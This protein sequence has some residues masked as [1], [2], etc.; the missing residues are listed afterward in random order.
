MEAER[1]TGVRDR[2]IT[3]A[4]S[5]RQV[6]SDRYT[7]SRLADITKMSL[8]QLSSDIP[9]AGTKALLIELAEMRTGLESTHVGNVCKIKTHEL[10]IAYP[11]MSLQQPTLP[12][13]FRKCRVH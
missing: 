7:A 6:E 4:F 9:G 11:F 12:K 3:A 13:I 10:G 5:R 2:R 1:E 8:E